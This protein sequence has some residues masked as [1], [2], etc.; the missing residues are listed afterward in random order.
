MTYEVVV[1]GLGGAGSS[2]LWA[3]ARR[4][5][6][7][8][9]IEQFEIGHALGS[10]HGRSRLFRGGAAEGAAYVDLA[11]R[12]LEIWR[13]LEQRSGN[14]IVTLTGGVTIA[15]EESELLYDTIAALRDR[16][17]EFAVLNADELRARHPQHRIL[18]EDAGVFDPATGIARPELAIHSAIDAAREHGAETLRATVT[19][20]EAVAGGYRIA[21]ANGDAV[22]TKRVIM[23]SG[24][25]TGG[26]LPAFADQ[27]TVR[28]AVL[29][30]FQPRPG[31]EDQFTPERFPVFTRQDEYE[32]GWGA[33][34]VD[35]YWVKIG[36]HDQ[37]GYEIED[38]ALNA[39]AVEPWELERVQQFCARQFEGLEPVARHPRG[40]MITVTADEH[41]SIGEVQPGLTMLAACSGHGFKHAAAVGDLGTRIALG[42]DP[43]FELSVFDPF[44]FNS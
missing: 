17:M 8:L 37:A 9:G 27:F 14:E 18:D 24:A 25:W 16:D 10:S 11:R 2:A 23:S 33:P 38:P 3:L 20:V 13:D 31:F 22:E 36:I 41:F 21:L 40:C 1:I 29:S 15:R 35:E 30:W 28:R 44:R 39:V 4:G 12:S 19:S 26:L 34:A 5:V 32:I 42:E 7:A 43:D 6:R